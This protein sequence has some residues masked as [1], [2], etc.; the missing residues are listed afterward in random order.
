MF[1]MLSYRYSQCD[2]IYYKN[3][4]KYGNTLGIHKIFCDYA[5]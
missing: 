3:N 2:V 1:M 4:D 5:I